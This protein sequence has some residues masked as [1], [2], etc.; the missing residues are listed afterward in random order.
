MTTT[1]TAAAASQKDAVIGD[2][3]AVQTLYQSLESR[4]GYRL[5]LG[6][7]RHFGYWE[8]DTWRMLPVGGPLRR[9]EEKLFESLDLPPG[10]RVLDAGCGVGHVSL[11]LAGRGLQ[12]TGIDI[13]DHHLEKARRN[14]AKSA[15]LS[16][17]VSIQKMDYHDLQTFE[18]G[19]FDGAFTMETLVHAD[20]AAKVAAELYRVLRPG[21]HIVLN[22]YD[23]NFSSEDEIGPEFAKAMRQ[24]SAHGAMP[25]WDVARKGYFERLLADAGFVDVQVQDYSE[26]VRPMLRLF[27][28]LA[29]IPNF[30]IQLLGLQRYF[31]N[32][33]GGAYAYN[34]REYWRYVSVSARKPSGGEP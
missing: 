32:T 15:P 34:A 5:V 2:H 7:T 19:S 27:W 3:P 8:R 20:D 21:G 26:N 14:I 30:F 1:T 4:I 31:I 23:Y 12:M 28:L 29:L 25:T 11:Y 24:M 6:G 13:T 17:R 9:M 18:P 16:S 33:V 22:E 10:S